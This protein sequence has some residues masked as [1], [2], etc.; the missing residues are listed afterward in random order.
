MDFSMVENAIMAV[1]MNDD[2]QPVILKMDSDKDKAK[3]SG[4]V[5]KHLEYVRELRNC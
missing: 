4:H 1:L 2:N 5:N 3:S